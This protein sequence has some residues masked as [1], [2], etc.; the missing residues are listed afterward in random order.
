[1]FLL[2]LD[3]RLVSFFPSGF[4]EPTCLRFRVR[5]PRRATYFLLR[6]SKNCNALVTTEETSYSVVEVELRITKDK[7]IMKCAVMSVMPPPG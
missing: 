1:M 6:R 7:K 5:G 2:F 3:E 4:P